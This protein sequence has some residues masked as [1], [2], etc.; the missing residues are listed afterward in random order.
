MRWGEASALLVAVLVA[1]AYS[2]LLTR[3]TGS[4]V[5]MWIA[6]GVVVGTLLRVAS[7]R[8]PTWVT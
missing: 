6:N 1:T 8:R 5:T 4:M 2:L 3:Q 7:D